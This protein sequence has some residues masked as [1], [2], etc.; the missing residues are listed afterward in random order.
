MTI[1]V[2]NTGGKQKDCSGFMNVIRNAKLSEEGDSKPVNNNRL[3][4][5]MSAKRG[6]K[7][8][9]SIGMKSGSDIHR[10]FTIPQFLTG[11]EPDEQYNFAP[12][13]F[14]AQGVAILDLDRNVKRYNNNIDLGLH[15]IH[16]YVLQHKN[17]RFGQHTPH[18]LTL[19]SL[20]R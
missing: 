11:S 10:I 14:K 19:T 16:Q 6:T 20:V 1:R 3:I 8:I 5:N 4:V 9:P 12:E 7:N 17:R 13:V 2:K 18:L 15:Y